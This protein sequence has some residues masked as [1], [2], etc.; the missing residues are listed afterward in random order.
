MQKNYGIYIFDYE[1]YSNNLSPIRWYK[2]LYAQTY[3]E[4]G[5]SDDP[6]DENEE[7]MY[8]GGRD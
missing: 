1:G 4:K 3:E 7:D 2:Q 6:V 8:D 5:N